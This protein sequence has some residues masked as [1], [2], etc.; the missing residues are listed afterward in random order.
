[1][2]NSVRSVTCASAAI[3]RVV[4][5]AYPCTKNRS[6][7]RAITRDLVASAFSARLVRGVISRAL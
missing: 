6:L 7:A 4:V 1:M 3:C 2:L 5:A